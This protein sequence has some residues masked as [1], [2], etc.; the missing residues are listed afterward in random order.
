[1]ESLKG[2]HI[3]VNDACV[4]CPIDDVEENVFALSAKTLFLKHSIFLT[5]WETLP[6]VDRLQIC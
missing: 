3:I 4:Q 6:A 2:E 1:M 5:L